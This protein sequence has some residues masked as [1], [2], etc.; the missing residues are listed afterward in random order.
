MKEFRIFNLSEKNIDKFISFFDKNNS[1]DIFL[2]INNN[3]LF[4]DT[5]ST[6]LYMQENKLINNKIILTSNIN[7]NATNIILLDDNFCKKAGLEKNAERDINTYDFLQKHNNT[8]FYLET[9]GSTGSPLLIQKYIHQ[10]INE[11]ICLK[12]FLAFKDY[13]K[14]ICSLVPHHHMYGLTFSIFLPII[15]NFSV[16]EQEPIIENFSQLKENILIASPEIL[17]KL[18]LWDKNYILKSL[19]N[20]ELIITAG[21]VLDDNIRKSLE[22]ITNVKILNIYG[23]TETGVIAGDLGDGFKIFKSVEISN[24][25]GHTQ[26]IS[27]WCESY[28]LKDEIKLMEDKLEI[29]GRSDRIVKIADKRFSLDMVEK[30]IKTSDLIYDAYAYIFKNRI[31]T[32]IS[33]SEKGKL[34]FRSKGKKEIVENIEKYTYNIF[35]KNIR[36]YK[37]VSYIYRNNN[38]KLVKKENDNLIDKK[39]E[40]EFKQ[41]SIKKDNNITYATFSSNIQEDIF[42]LPSHFYNFPLIPGF[43]TLDS[44]IK[45][46]E[47]F[48]YDFSKINKISNLKFSNFVRPFDKILVELIMDNNIVKF[49]I[50][51]GDIKAASGSIFYGE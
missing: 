24:N 45:L 31:G 49:I 35:G 14:K 16:I 8:F 48:G 46:S 30:Y 27:N 37:I 12:E 32:L 13:S 25:N 18:V 47:N 6:L 29:Y 23:S 9:S 22:N 15:Y 3:L 7:K 51:V 34:A 43:I 11:A 2:N 28:I 19:E 41:E 42:Y 5:L 39:E 33:L 4:I 36:H 40:L 17:K 1:S 26:V 10:M 50:N 21:S 38:G 20:I 44:I